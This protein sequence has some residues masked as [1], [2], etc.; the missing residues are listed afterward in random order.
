MII[1]LNNSSVALGYDGSSVVAKFSSDVIQ[2]LQDGLVEPSS[3]SLFSLGTDGDGQGLNIASD[4]TDSLILD[5]LIPCRFITPWQNDV[6]D[7]DYIDLVVHPY[8]GFTAAGEQN[9]FEIYV[10]LNGG[11]AT[12]AFP[13]TR[14]GRD[15]VDSYTVYSV[16]VPSG[17]S[18]SSTTNEIRAV[19]IPKYGTPIILQRG[20][21]SG[22]LDLA[23]RGVM[24]H[25]YDRVTI[26]TSGSG[27]DYY[28][29]LAAYVFTYNECVSSCAGW[30]GSGLEPH[31]YVYSSKG[32][33]IVIANNVTSTD[34]AAG[35]NLRN[36]QVYNK[37]KPGTTQATRFVDSNRCPGYTTANFD[38][39][40]NN[41]TVYIQLVSCSGGI[42]KNTTYSAQTAIG[43]SHVDAG[44][45]IAQQ[46]YE[47]G[48][49]PQHA[50]S[51]GVTNLASSPLPRA[52]SHQ[53]NSSW[54]YAGLNGNESI[55][56]VV[57]NKGPGAD[58]WNSHL[59]VNVHDYGSC[60]AMY[61]WMSCRVDTVKP[62]GYDYDWK[63]DEYAP[64][65]H[66][67]PDEYG[68][69]AIRANEV[70]TELA[71]NEGIWPDFIGSASA[72]DYA[73][74]F[75]FDEIRGTFIDHQ[76]WE[77][78][79]WDDSG[80]DRNFIW[81][82]GLDPHL[83]SFQWSGYQQLFG[84]Y[85]LYAIRSFGSDLERQFVFM[86]EA[87]TSCTAVWDVKA[88]SDSAVATLRIGMD[89]G[90]WSPARGEDRREGQHWGPTFYCATLA[91]LTGATE[92]QQLA[93][94]LA[95]G[96]LEQDQVQRGFIYNRTT[97][98]NFSLYTIDDQGAEYMGL[99]DNGLRVNPQTSNTFNGGALINWTW[100][101]LDR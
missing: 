59:A 9:S 31:P 1:K 50:A 48:L 67:D 2:H 96:T 36:C 16:R 70:D 71:K 60:P 37:P 100:V 4:D 8:C 90:G 7:L 91:D 46:Y 74:L 13:R 23:Q 27:A 18:P 24:A 22:T 12:R 6:D 98:P 62:V 58:N 93:S 10:Y 42:K 95:K 81:N 34:V 3:W 75:F 86:K 84:P 57:E 66:P 61:P 26:G 14:Q 56:C 72:T 33:Q 47:L 35:I 64:D 101:I 82:S 21:S 40:N 39:R 11:P 38:I 83:D 44:F 89:Y 30:G 77:T 32:D 87:T 5:N 54:R 92:T 43:Q 41:G 65:P 73:T 29:V 15:S 19:A 20:M 53:T 17:W 85:I 63:K 51:L 80:G 25:K 99:D 68:Y 69:T 97:D 94:H 76:G 88:S 55:D 45:G 52:Q 78:T 49:K 28:S 79:T